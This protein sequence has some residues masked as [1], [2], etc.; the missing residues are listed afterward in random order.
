[1]QFRSNKVTYK[2]KA[3]K[4]AKG[5]SVKKVDSVM[6]FMIFLAVIGLFYVWNGHYAE[7]QIKELEAVRK[8]LKQV[9]SEYLLRQST[10]SAA[11]R[12]SE[13]KSMADTLG[14][15]PLTEPPMR[16]VIQSEEE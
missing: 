4:A 7:Q 15:R 14:L 9:K 12:F 2:G 11:T 8:E 1:M 5:L 13:V 16:V 6:R 10:L 3:D